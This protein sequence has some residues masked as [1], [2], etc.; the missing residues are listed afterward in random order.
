MCLTNEIYRK[1]SPEVRLRHLSV[2][3]V[4][5]NKVGFMKFGDIFKKEVENAPSNGFVIYSGQAWYSLKDVGESYL[6]SAIKLTSQFSDA[7]AKGQEHHE[8]NIAL[9]CLYLIRHA[10][11]SYLKYY[12]VCLVNGHPHH[13]NL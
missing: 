1:Y 9:P 12:L 5:F 10:L 8:D 2:Y 13:R 4:A 11:E 7:E 6:E 3:Y